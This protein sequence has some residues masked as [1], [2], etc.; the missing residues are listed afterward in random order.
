M[1]GKLLSEWLYSSGTVD[2]TIRRQPSWESNPGLSSLCPV[3]QT[4]AVRVLVFSILYYLSQW[5]ETTC[6]PVTFSLNSLFFFLK[7]NAFL[8]VHNSLWPCQIMPSLSLQ[9]SSTSFPSHALLPVCLPSVI[10]AVPVM[11]AIP[12]GFCVCPLGSNHLP[13]ISFL[14]HPV[15]FPYPFICS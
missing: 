10:A 11:R 12:Q 14:V 6:S 13:V 7:K 1:G 9:G 5:S 8:E 15:H 3:T 4:S 2:L